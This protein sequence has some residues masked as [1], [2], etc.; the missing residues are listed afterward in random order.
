MSI[1]KTIEDEVMATKFMTMLSMLMIAVQTGDKKTVM[2]TY[3]HW[4]DELQKD[5]GAFAG[6]L[7][8]SIMAVIIGGI[9]L[10]IGL[11]VNA[12][13]SSSIPVVN[14]A[15]YN[16]TL[17]TTKTNVNTAFTLL[18]IILIVGGAAGIIAVLMGFGGGGRPR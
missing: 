5:K 12:V 1:L 6:I 16:T 10:Y 18:G 3:Y 14:D 8:A 2:A 7:I 17:S 4:V 15:N 11:F 9:M 13:V